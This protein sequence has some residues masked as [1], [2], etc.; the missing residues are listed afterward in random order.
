MKTKQMT[1][2][3]CTITWTEYWQDNHIATPHIEWLVPDFNW[4]FIKR[5]MTRTWQLTASDTV[6]WNQDQALNTSMFIVRESGPT[7]FLLKEENN[8][9]KFKVCVCWSLRFFKEVVST[10]SIFHVKFLSKVFMCDNFN[11]SNICDLKYWIEFP[12]YFLHV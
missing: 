2:L 10:C 8:A 5:V 11:V 7:C 3:V 9:K 6:S 12:S 1:F 4:N